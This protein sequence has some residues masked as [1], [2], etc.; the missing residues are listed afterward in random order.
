VKLSVWGRGLKKR[1]TYGNAESRK[2]L[3][4]Q[5]PAENHGSTRFVICKRADAKQVNSKGVVPPGF[6]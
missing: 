2:E 5:M 4:H 6:V 3:T 1:L